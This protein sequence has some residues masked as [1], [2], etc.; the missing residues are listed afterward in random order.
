[1]SRSRLLESI[2]LGGALCAGLFLLGTTLGQSLIE[3]R[4]YERSVTVKGLSVREVPADIAIWPI[5][6][7]SVGNDLEGVYRDLETKTALIVEFLK[8]RGFEDGE[9][10][11]GI[12]AV[13][14]KQAQGHYD[15]ARIK[16]R[17]SANQTITVY[18][19]RPEDVRKSTAD[20]IDLGKAGVALSQHGY[21]EAIQYL[22]SGLNEIK[23][24]MVEEATRK[25]REVAKKFAEDSDSRLG[26]IKKA[27]QGQFSIKDRDSNNPHIKR[28]R[29]VNTVEYYLSD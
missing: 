15:A 23:P 28:V 29:V 19:D 18:S 14:D 11:I 10:T 8:A 2:V 4:G 9:I 6:F 3:F 7:I 20:L 17:Y 12:P 5:S 21:N 22:F 13:N 16:F 24:E 25:A 26:K 27:R 1:M